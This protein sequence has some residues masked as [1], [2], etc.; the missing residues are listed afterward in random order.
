M[1]E[2]N[3]KLY[4]RTMFQGMGVSAGALGLNLPSAHIG[5]GKQEQTNQEGNTMAP[6]SAQD[7]TGANNV[8]SVADGEFLT[9]DQGCV[10]TMIRIP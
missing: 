8:A 2:S 10:S 3:S 6:A 1:A 4:R 5:E 9:T 7:P